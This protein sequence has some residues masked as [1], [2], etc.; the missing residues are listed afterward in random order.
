VPFDVGVRPDRAHGLTSADAAERLAAVGPNVLPRAAGASIWKRIAE[1]F[2]QFFAVMLWVAGG[3][4]IVAGLPELGVAIFA[5]IVLNGIF[6]FA[7]EHR[8]ERTADRLR[9]LLPRMV[10]VVRD[11][12]RSVVAASE[13]VPDDVVVLGEGDRVSADVRCIEAHALSIDTSTLTGESVPDRVGEGD[14]V[15]AGTFVLEG[16]GIAVVTATGANTELARLAVLTQDTTRP[17]TPLTRELHRLVRTIAMIAVTAGTSFFLLTL[18]NDTPPSDGFIF[19]IGIT[20][21]L[22][23]EGLLPT[24]TLSLALGAQRMADRNALVRRLESVETLGSSTFIC[25][26]KTGTL[27]QNRMRVVEVWSPSGVSTITGDGYAPTGEITSADPGATA[28]LPE[29]MLAARACSSGR[30]VE[31]DG[32]WIAQGDPMEAAIDG[33]ARLVHPGE[34]LEELTGSITARFPFDPRRRCASVIAPGRVLT[35][36]APDAVL[37]RCTSGTSGAVAAMEAMTA[38]GLRVLAVASRRVE[39]PLPTSAAEAETD[40]HLLG[41]LGFRDPPRP[42]A[43][44]ALTACRCA[45]IRVAMVTGDHPATAT[46]IA[47]LVGL[48]PP[49]G[50]VL[51]GADLPDDDQMLAEMVDRDGIVIARV[52]PEDKLRI[53][54]ALQSRGHVVA[55]TGDGVN[56]GPALREADI[57]I[58]MGASGSDVAREAADL[59]LLDDNFATIVAA[60]EL[61]RAT[62]A[63]ARR[64]LT[65]HLTDNVAE[66]TPFAIWALSGGRF[67]LALGVLQVLALDIGTDTLSATALGAEAPAPHVLQQPPTR[68]R[69]LDR[70]VATR[71]FGVLG[72]TEAAFEMGAFVVGL[73][74]AGW[75]PGGEFPTGGALAAA[76]GAAFMTVVVAQTANAFACRSALLPAWRLRWTANRFLLVAATLELAFAIVLIVVPACAAL[77]DHRAP[78]AMTWPVILA[79]APAMLV[80]D[81]L[82]KRWRRRRTSNPLEASSDC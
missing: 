31:R 6:A 61:G 18:L 42:E 34:Q 44:D 57:G 36:G 74:V 40:L 3:L 81:G 11:G 53:A 14:V 48:R 70:T 38:R 4:A 29:L 30:T 68:G 65:Y 8:A 60:I 33:L 27:T 35:K 66:M 56:D 5:V 10:T 75:R 7:Q 1:Q 80:V 73:L 12:V 59:V 50:P 15:R 77:V 67:P 64:F 39:A 76:S 2:V 20:V 43:R 13:L 62:F 55:M 32:R 72:P 19:A 45:G 78:P 46:A 26:D 25:T 37:T 49:D 52:S 58:A 71:A 69:L 16:E 41:L 23:P 28:A 63:N 22:V 51:L 47:D 82:W 17:D 24:V 21:A 79:S 54:R 9:D